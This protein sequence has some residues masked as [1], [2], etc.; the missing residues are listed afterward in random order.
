MLLFI[1]VLHIPSERA[2]DFNTSHVT[3]YR[4]RVLRASIR[5]TSF[6]YISC[7]CLSKIM[8]PVSYKLYNFNTSHVTVYLFHSLSFRICSCISIH[9]MLLFIYPTVIKGV[10]LIVFQYISCYCL[11]LLENQYKC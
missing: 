8:N 6:Q 7:Y 1:K 9:L 10:Q 5:Q 2:Q 11:S 4:V 3:V